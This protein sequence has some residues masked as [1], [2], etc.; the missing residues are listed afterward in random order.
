MNK[1]IAKFDS[2]CAETGKR[3][4]KGTTIYYNTITRLAYHPE[5]KAVKNRQ[6]RPP[7]ELLQ[8]DLIE[9]MFRKLG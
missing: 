3:L 9:A 2:R 8:H 5:A 7:G 4:K 1:I 6:N